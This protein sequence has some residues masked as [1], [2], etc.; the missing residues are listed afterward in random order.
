MLPPLRALLDEVHRRDPSP[1]IFFLGDYVNRGPDSRG[2]IDHLLTLDGAR[3]IRGN[4]DDMFD[5]ILHGHCE[6]ENI[7]GKDRL[8][9]F[10]WFMQHGLD[11]TLHSYGASASQLD[12]LLARPQME[13]LDEVLA[14]VPDAHR[15]FMRE[16]PL[17]AGDED[18]FIVHGQWPVDVHTLEPGIP[19]R[20]DRHAKLRGIAIWGRYN[21]LAIAQPKVWERTGFVGHT[22][23]DNYAPAKGGAPMLPV[24]GDKLVLLDTAVALVEHGR[25][26]AWCVD[27]QT[28]I[29]TDRQARLV[30]S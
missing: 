8:A 11:T 25:L 5:L 3:F 29:Q 17:T 28:F 15:A 18:F 26:T 16:L 23:V 4:H 6:A 12:Y 22:P 21:E 7:A 30:T 13:M 27:S 2:V 24:V 14:G 19:S 20:L 1:R 10:K 9:A